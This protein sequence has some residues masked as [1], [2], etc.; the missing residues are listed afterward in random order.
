V[1]VSLTLRSARRFY[2]SSSLAELVTA[3]RPQIDDARETTNFAG[4]LERNERTML[5]NTPNAAATATAAPAADFLTILVAGAGK[6]AAKRYVDLAQPPD[7]YDAGAFFVPI[8]QPVAN[9]DELVVALEQL[10]GY[11]QAFVVRGKVKGAPQGPILRRSNDRPGEPAT[12][13]QAAHLWVALDADETTTPFDPTDPRGSVERWRATLPAG[14]RDAACIFHFSAKQHQKPNVRGR[15][16]FWAER[17]ITDAEGDAWCRENGLDPAVFRTVQPIYTADPVFDGCVDPLDRS[18]VRLPGGLARFDLSPAALA[19]V[20]AP[21]RVVLERE[22]GEHPGLFYSL[23]EA[24]GDIVGADGENKWI[25][26]CPK[27]DEHSSPGG[28]GTVLWAA[29]EGQTLGVIYCSHSSHGHDKFSAQEW[30]ACFSAEERS[31]VRAVNDPLSGVWDRVECL[32]AA[33]DSPASAD[34]VRIYNGDLS[35]TVDQTIAAIAGGPLFQRSGELVRIT[36]DAEPDASGVVRPHG[37]PT[38]RTLP[39]ERLT[40]IVEQ[41]CQFWTS[42]TKTPKASKANPAPEPITKEKNV[43]APPR[44][45]NTLE[46]RGEWEGIRPLRGVTDFPVLRPDGTVI[47]EP[48]YDAETGTLSNVS[49]RLDVPAAPTQADAQRALEALLDLVVD[50]PFKDDLAR[51]SWLAG[52]LTPIARP[53]VNGPTPMLLIDANTRGA[54][55]T[56]LAELVGQIVLGATL[57]ARTAPESQEE[58]KKVIFAIALAGDPIILIDNVTRML[59]SAALD[60]VLTSKRYGDR[61]LG[62]SEERTVDVRTFFIATSNNARI[63]TDLVRRSLHCRLLSNQERPESR[64]GFRHPDLVGFTRANRAALLGAAVTVLR[65]YIVAG[66]PAVSLRHMGSFEAWSELVRAP[67]VWL[68]L[69]DPTETQDALRDDADPERDDLGELLRAWYQ[70]F[71]ER[72]VTAAEVLAVGDGVDRRALLGALEALLDGGGKAP[73]KGPTAAALGYRLRGLRDTIVGDLV[74]RGAKT[75][76]GIEWQVLRVAGPG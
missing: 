20:N 62:V 41:R 39:T 48:G 52:L 8:V 55:K 49:I 26:T 42:E 64:S 10:R 19:Q 51:A 9:L 23:L 12:L 67:L 50:F 47:S 34:K 63:S 66:R 3:R 74:L 21:R 2:R 61:I 30:L 7:D 16:W 45:V 60:S 11:P 24:R 53:A 33:N 27:E 6:R 65:A 57:P 59:R 69:P 14:L 58:W 15:A 68:G 29:R 43:C 38:I 71:G 46:A 4:A 76:L 1:C 44:V 17:P 37:A 35:A 5:N 25:V 56:L 73:G 18:L 72:A 22:P 28:V 36:R 54:G 40:E 70:T 32:K 75:K 31:A 13:E